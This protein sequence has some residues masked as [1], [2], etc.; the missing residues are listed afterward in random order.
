MK[1]HLLGTVLLSALLTS[2]SHAEL[3]KLAVSDVK[4]GAGLVK[5]AEK[6][7]T[8][9]SLQRV[10]EAYD[11]QLID[12]LHGTRKFD[13]LARSDLKQLAKDGDATGNTFKIPGADYLLVTTVDDFQDYSES[14]SLQTTGQVLHKRV[15]RIVAVA[16]I[17]DAATGRLIESA[18]IKKEVKDAGAQFNS[19]KNGDLA[20]A[21][22]ESAVEQSAS[23]MANR[24]AD[25][26][27]PAK[28]IA[29]VDKTVM[30]NRGDGT[31]IAVGQVWQVW[32]L[33]AELK[34]SDTGEVLGR[35]KF[36]VGKVRVTQVDPKTSTAEI[37]EDTGISEGAMVHPMK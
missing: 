26:I 3:K 30:I 34:D 35:Q 6:A 23:A 36:A 28:V 33:G 16:K 25:V 19:E 8:I 13:I 17:Y 14:L 2:V 4:A 32:A 37:V 20:D 11:S 12:R 31:D 21:V 10:V 22:I 18:N 1:L 27:Y 24:I 29:K 5:S 9:V 15:V 7:G